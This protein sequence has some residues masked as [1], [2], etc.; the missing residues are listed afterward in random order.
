M[1]DYSIGNGNTQKVIDKQEADEIM[2]GE[3][4]AIG[5]AIDVQGGDAR[6]V[7]GDYKD[8]PAQGIPIVKDQAMYGFDPRGHDYFIYNDA[9]SGSITV[10]V[11]PQYFTLGDTGGL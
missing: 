8:Q 6:L 3:S 7:H 5:Y 10:N 11:T 9:A 1:S 2:R 4:G